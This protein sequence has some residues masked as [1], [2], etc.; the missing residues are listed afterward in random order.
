MPRRPAEIPPDDEWSQEAAKTFWWGNWRD[1]SNCLFPWLYEDGQP[2]PR[3][4]MKD[5]WGVQ[6]FPVD[7]NSEWA[8]GRPQWEVYL[9]AY[10]AW[11][12]ETCRLIEVYRRKVEELDY[13]ES[14]EV[15]EG[16]FPDVPDYPTA[17]ADVLVAA[18]EPDVVAL[19][20]ALEDPDSDV[21]CKDCGLWTPLMYAAFAGS[22]ECV[23]YLVDNGA[24]LDA[25]N[26]LQDTAYD[27]AI[28][29]FAKKQP[30]HPVLRFLRETRRDWEASAPRGAGW[31]SKLAA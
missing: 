31:R 15:Y 4:P 3:Y 27:I 10:D 5:D 28:Q 16:K 23:E 26:N 12:R 20:D 8:R 1:P 30:D 6:P 25:R 21:N 29:A 7:Y 22:I 24:N 2:R 14:V 13:E 17:N 11:N 18:A 19:A 9:D